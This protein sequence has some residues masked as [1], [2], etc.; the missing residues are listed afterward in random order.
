MK[1]NHSESER[2]ALAVLKEDQITTAVVISKLQAVAIEQLAAIPRIE[3]EA[4]LRAILAGV[5]LHRVKSGLV[6]GEFRRW[7]SQMST[8]GG[9]LPAVSKTQVNYYM[10][11]ATV[12]L[13]K[14]SATKPELLAVLG[15][16][17][18]LSLEPADANAR[19]FMDKLVKFVGTKS[20]NEL[21][22]DHGIKDGKKLGGARDKADAEAPI[23]P[24]Q[25]AEQAREELSAWH[26]TGR[27]LL[28]TDNLCSRLA[29]DEILTFDDALDAMLAQW[30]RGLKDTLAKPA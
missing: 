1:G 4:A 13:A 9:H 20:L 16:Q 22:R 7:L 8:S 30:R 3:R 23:D 6:H 5:T 15:D 12:A 25:L 2:A 21:L 26:E 24:E 18:E 10:R 27:Q 29:P 19:R 17:T 11:L 14:T 28:L